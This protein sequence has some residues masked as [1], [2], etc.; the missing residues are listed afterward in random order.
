MEGV[1]RDLTAKGT[2]VVLATHLIDQGLALTQAR[3]HLDHGR[4]V[5]PEGAA[6]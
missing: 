4:Q 6:A 5:A 1:I 3:L 2:T